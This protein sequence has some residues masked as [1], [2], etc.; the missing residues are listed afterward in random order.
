MAPV[1]A[2]ACRP[3]PIL[4]DAVPDQLEPPR[5][6]GIERRVTGHLIQQI[7]YTVTV[8]S[9][10]TTKFMPAMREAGAELIADFDPDFDDACELAAEIY[11]A[12]ERA[13][14]PQETRE[15]R[16]PS[17]L[18]EFRGSLSHD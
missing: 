8:T 16:Y 15:Q 10:P 3:H 9:E 14:S 12:M 2:T 6:P 11:R 17:V 4:D 13:S 5:A 7:K 18:S 1:R